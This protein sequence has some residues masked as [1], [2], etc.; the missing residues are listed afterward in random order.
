M[1]HLLTYLFLILFIT[2]CTNQEEGTLNRIESRSI[3]EY[4]CT[5]FRNVQTYEFTTGEVTVYGELHCSERTTYNIIF[6]Y[7]GN[8]GSSYY[9]YIGDMQITPSNGSSFRNLT[10]TLEPGIHKCMLAILFSGANQQ[11]NA[12]YYI[13][14]TDG[15][16]DINNKEDYGDIIAEGIS[17]LEIV[18]SGEPEH[19]NCRKC[20]FINSIAV[21]ECVSC[22]ESKEN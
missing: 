4:T 16:F 20:N 15:I 21:D 3:N 11:A 17:T 14:S 9:G 5:Y 12:R 1:K 2:S 7:T 10:V 13:Q 18:G 6:S 22:G 8:T 19:W